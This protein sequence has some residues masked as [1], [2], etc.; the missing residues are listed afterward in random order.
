[1][2]AAEFSGGFSKKYNGAEDKTEHESKKYTVYG[3]TT[4]DGVGLSRV[5]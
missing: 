2:S 3:R 1:M 5:D 4:L